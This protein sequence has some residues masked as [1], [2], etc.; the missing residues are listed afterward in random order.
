CKIQSIRDGICCANTPSLL[1]NI[2]LP[3]QL[4]VCARSNRFAMVFAVQIHHRSYN[5]AHHRSYN[6]AHHRSYN[7]AHHRS[8]NQAHHRSYNKFLIEVGDKVAA[9]LS[10]GDVLAL[11]IVLKLVIEDGA[12]YEVLAFGVCEVVATDS[13]RRQHGVATG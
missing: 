1:Q 4:K 5:Q 10:R 9:T 7:Q 11:A 6:Q 13:R 3:I 2:R 12:E 8:Y